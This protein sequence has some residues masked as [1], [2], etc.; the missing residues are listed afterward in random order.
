M[1]KPNTT[2]NLD[3][4]D[5]ELIEVALHSVIANTQQRFD[6]CGRCAELNR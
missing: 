4:K 1:A 6:R 5:L 2:F 3:V